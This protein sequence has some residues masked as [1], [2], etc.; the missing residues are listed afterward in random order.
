MKS[1][2]FPSIVNLARNK[3]QGPIS[4]QL[5]NV[6][7][8]DLS[9]NNFIGSIPTQIGEISAIWSISLF[10]NKIH[11]PV[12][13]S[14][15]QSTNV[16]Q[17]LDLSNNSLYGT[18][19]RSLGNCK[20]LIYLNL[21]QNKLT[22]S[23]PKKL[24]LITSLCYLDLNGDQFEGSFPVVLEKFQEMK[25]LKLVGNRFEGRITKFIGDLHHLRILVLASNSFNESIPERVMKLENL[26]FISLSRNKLS[27]PIPENLEGLKKMTKTQNQ[28]TILGYYYSLKFTGA[29]LEIVT[30]GQTR[31]LV[32]VYSYNTGFDVSSNALTVFTV[33][34]HFYLLKIHSAT[35]GII[36]TIL[37][38]VGIMSDEMKEI[39]EILCESI[40]GIQKGDQGKGNSISEG[41]EIYTP[42]G[43]PMIWSTS[44]STG[45]P[46]GFQHQ[47]AIIMVFKIPNNSKL[48]HHNGSLTCLT[49]VEFPHFDGTNLRTWMYKADQFFAY[50]DT[51]VV[52]K[53]R[54][55]TLHFD[56]IAIEWHLFYLKS[57]LYL[58][59][60]TWE[61]YIYVLM[62]RFG[63]EYEDPMA[64]FKLVKQHGTVK[65][66]MKECDRIMAR[67]NI[68]PEHAISG[69]ITGLKMDIGF[70]LKSYRPFTLP[71]AYQ[72]ARNIES[73]FQAQVRVS[74]N[75]MTSDGGSFK[76]GGYSATLAR[77]MGSKKKPAISFNKERSKRMTQAEISEK[78]QKGYVFSVIKSSYLVTNV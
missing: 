74:R 3:L 35:F 38:S 55:A 59:F 10:G 67:L 17:V 1:S 39:K 26:Q 43:N 24:E 69:F 52:Q 41:A 2:L 47:L 64:E 76:K 28:T 18:I 73:Q 60:P 66:Y 13:E 62:D 75:H 16:L 19:P 49:K 77:I 63:G 46:P 20:S 7:V 25:I 61:E 21:G 27:G 68:L 33:P 22:G 53:V 23:V 30:K 56:D 78:R 34:L 36:A 32:S 37:S 9:L 44:V 48:H 11:G 31:F 40:H 6:N 70:V 12:L 72:L 51:P 65:E 42:S 14:F 8:I 5:K 71:H 50:D 54:E 15:C 4:T 45:N 58:Q 29:L 57:R